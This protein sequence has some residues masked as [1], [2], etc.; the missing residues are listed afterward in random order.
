MSTRTAFERVAGRGGDGRG[1]WI[2]WVHGMVPARV[3][4]FIK[5]SSHKTG[6]RSV[7]QREREG[8][9]EQGSWRSPSMIRMLITE[10]RSQKQ[11]PN[12]FYCFDKCQKETGRE[13][14]GR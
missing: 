3:F 4:E 9:N 5:G 7:R 11:K 6:H 14:E 8:E 2:E 13:R 10:K 12:N 1:E